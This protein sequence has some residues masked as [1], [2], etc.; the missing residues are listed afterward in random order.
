[1]IILSLI[2][3]GNVYNLPIRG[4]KQRGKKGRQITKKTNLS[5]F[6]QVGVCPWLIAATEFI[7]RT[8]NSNFD[9]LG[10]NVILSNKKLL[11][12]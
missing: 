3:I 1:M 2:R 12:M 11:Q 4:N 8:S 9:K 6:Y 5:Y 7:I 10:S